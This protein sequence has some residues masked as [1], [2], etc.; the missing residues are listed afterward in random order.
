MKIAVV[1]FHLNTK[2]GS[3]RQV[4]EL[5]YALMAANHNVVIYSVACD[6]ERSYG[7]LMKQLNIKTVRVA[8]PPSAGNSVFSLLLRKI[9]YKQYYK[10][11][12]RQIAAI[13]PSDVDMIN[14]QDEESYKVFY[15]WKKIN[16]HKN[17]VSFSWTMNDPPFSYKKKDGFFMEA[18]RLV[19]IFFELIYERRFLNATDVIFVLDN[20][21]Q[22]MVEK[23]YGKKSI[24]IGSG[25]NFQY[26]YQ[27]P[28]K[29][30]KSKFVK[31]LGVGIF[32]PYRR[33]EDI[34]SAVR[35]LR[36]RGYKVEANII[37]DRSSD[38]EYSRRLEELVI[39]FRLQ[40][41]V[42]FLGKVGE[43]ELLNAYHASDIF[44]FP[45]HMQTFG[46]APAE[47]MAAGLPVI[48]SKTAGFSEFVEDM[49]NAL[50]VA[51]LRPD[52]IAERISWLIENPM[53][54][55]R[56]AQNGQDFV[57]NNLSWERRIKEMIFFCHLNRQ[58]GTI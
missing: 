54:Y 44:I 28:H 22:K 33:F 7:E 49:K 31:L 21:N 16:P 47:A 39:S 12:A 56:L 35:I 48:I 18:A 11:A 26:F 50:L 41:E 29:L 30:D 13:I 58:T 40:K 42:K 14:C 20:R 8:N 17:S 6:Y 19:F 9:R 3:Q 2:G 25:V 36:D 1:F 27:L 38:I 55:E 15:Y 37:G 4:L 51:P 24:I 57:R 10:S 52:Q 43:K 23:Y 34:I 5:A 45:N 32:L 46:L 53:E